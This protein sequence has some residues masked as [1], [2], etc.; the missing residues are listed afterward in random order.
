VSTEF[1]GRVVNQV[2]AFFV[3]EFGNYFNLRFSLFA[4]FPDSAKYLAICSTID[5]LVSPTNLVYLGTF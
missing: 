5:S 2:K 1:G 4:K 3:R